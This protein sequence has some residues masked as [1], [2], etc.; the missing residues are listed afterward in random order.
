MLFDAI[1][2]LVPRKK[3]K[4]DP[5]A[6]NFTQWEPLPSPEIWTW[7][8]ISSSLLLHERGQFQQS[9]RLCDSLLRDDF[10]NGLIQTRLLAIRGLPFEFKP[11]DDEQLRED[12]KR[13]FPESVQM[14]VTFW[15]LFMGF[16]IA[17]LQYDENNV[18]TVKVWH[19]GNC[20]WDKGGRFWRVSTREG[21]IPLVGENEPG[22]GKWVLFKNWIDERPWMAGIARAVGLLL[23]LRYTNLD[24]WG[25]SNHAAG[26][27]SKVV[28][29]PAEVTETEDA[30]ETIEALKKLNG[31][32]VIHL[33]ND[34]S[35]E[36]LE[37]KYANWESFDKLIG[38]VESNMSILILGASDIVNSGP[39]GSRARAVVQDRPRQDRLENDVRILATTTHDEILPPYYLWNRHEQDPEIPDA[40][41]DATP[42]EDA[43]RQA[44]ARQKEAQA[45]A[46]ASQ[47]LAAVYK[48]G[49]DKYISIEK[50]CQH[51]AGNIL[52]DEGETNPPLDE[53]PPEPTK[54][55]P[56]AKE[57]RLARGAE[58][59]QE[60]GHE[61]VL[62]KLAVPPGGTPGLRKLID[63][64][65]SATSYADLRTR[66]ATAFEGMS[67][68][69]LTRELARGR[70]LA[71]L[72]GNLAV[73]T[74]LENR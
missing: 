72:A 71:E 58:S 41:W 73:L 51:F 11:D 46:Q 48:L 34:M 35:L 59:A 23:L 21:L 24:D 63:A 57:A 32:S 30:Q 47:A 56:E 16:C 68:K 44:E 40:C 49:G 37:Q 9:A 19:P 43:V 22:K 54:P 64:V 52:L 13:I 74:D 3:D 8:L 15:T 18:P 2:N 38:R 65:N 27:P 14:E 39:S 42:P 12:W 36:Y 53:P 10:L 33:F 17:E 4:V 62:Q 50:F 28:K 26:R 29:M 60:T 25:R 31:G 67:E 70:V 55:P 6:F 5:L 45:L 20:Y 61:Y 66:V 69:R 1:R 7:G